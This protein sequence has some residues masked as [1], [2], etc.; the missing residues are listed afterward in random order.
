MK[1]VFSNLRIFLI[2]VTTVVCSRTVY[3][4]NRLLIAGDSTS[5]AVVFHNIPDITFVENWSDYEE[6]IDINENGIDDIKFE[7]IYQSHTTEISYAIR[8]TPI[9]E[10]WFAEKDTSTYSQLKVFNNGDSIDNRCFWSN[11]CSQSLISKWTSNMPPAGT[12]YGGAWLNQSNKYLGVRYIENQDTLYAWVELTGWK[13]G[14]RIQSYANMKNS[15]D[16]VEE[17]N[18]FR[19]Y[20]N[21]A[22][23]FITI[24]ISEPVTES[25]I[26]ILGITGQV[27][28]KYN[29]N[30]ALTQIDISHMK[31]GIY[32]VQLVNSEKVYSLKK[33]I[34][35]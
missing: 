7:S 34:I 32:F 31:R 30:K 12:S 25:Y 20:P 15:S 1:K 11:C 8:A 35:E 26:A 23:E 29:I 17:I 27:L 28:I 2:L 3:T 9:N 16:I 24:E 5:S 21:P 6:N 19:I 18:D 4:Q 33:I 10:C 14:L 22:N 13:V